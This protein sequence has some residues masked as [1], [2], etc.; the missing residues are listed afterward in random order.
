MTC[1]CSF[2]EILATTTIVQRFAM[3]TS[4]LCC[5]SYFHVNGYKTVLTL[6]Y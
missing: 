2:L 3:M 6:I 5:V 4:K 1:L